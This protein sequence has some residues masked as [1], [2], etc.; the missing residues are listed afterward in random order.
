MSEILELIDD[1]RLNQQIQERKP[2]YIDLCTYRLKELVKG[3]I[4]YVLVNY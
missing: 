2:A 3:R 4:L 1:F